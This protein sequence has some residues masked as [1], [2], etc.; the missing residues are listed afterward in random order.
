MTSKMRG[1]VLKQGQRVRLQSPGG[2]GY[3]PASERPASEVARD[4][5]LGYLSAEQ[6]D[7]AYG[8]DWRGTAE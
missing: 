8:N 5:A 6:A 2:G 3:G 7:A 1:I 4:V